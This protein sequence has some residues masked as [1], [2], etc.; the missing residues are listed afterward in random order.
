VS[1][2]R[3]Q[4]SES[5]RIA[6]NGVYLDQV[7]IRLHSDSGGGFASYESAP[8]EQH[9]AT[10]D[11][12]GISLQLPALTA[13][14]LFADGVL[15]ADGI[16]AVELSVAGRAAK[17]LYFHWLHK[18]PSKDAGSQVVL[19]FETQPLIT[20]GPGDQ[21]AWLKQI[22]PLRL[23]ATGLWDPSEENWGEDDEP[24][25]AWA[26]AIIKRGPRR[27]YE[28]ENIIPGSRVEDDNDPILKANELCEQGRVPQAKKL[29]MALLSRDIRCIDAHAHLGNLT[30]DKEPHAALRHYRRGVQI[31]DLTLG[32]DFDGVLPWRVV[33]NR[34]FLRCLH[35]L[36][37][38]LWRLGQYEEAQGLFARLL[39]LSPSDNLG[40]RF[41]LPAIEAR[42]P[43][44]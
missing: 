18:L 28:L 14:Q 2:D 19:R 20:T 15:T 9:S 22:S 16:K 6:V 21:E 34:P 23:E 25:P 17:T 12:A 4:A 35:G 32:A 39:W 42:E 3:P 38:C 27:M 11:S 40:V 24:L 41:L 29:L 33:D 43:W 7:R 1:K 44:S 8:V 10:E 36:A 5:R 13:L 37:L 30:F 26:N 31:G